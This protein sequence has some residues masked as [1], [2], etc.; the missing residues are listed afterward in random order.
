MNYYE[1]HLGDYAKD[2]G[3]LSMLEHGAYSLLLD[4][5]YT[6]EQ[7]IP[8]DQAHRVCRARSKE[9]KAAV[10][11][12][13]AEFF[14]LAAGFWTN[15]RADREIDKMRAKVKA[16]QENGKLG[17]RPKQ[18]QREP[19]GF[20]VGSHLETQPKAHQSPDTIHQS[21][22]K[23]ANAPSRAGAVCRLLREHGMPKTSP[24][25]PLLLKLLDAGCS[26]AE[27]LAFVPAA[28]GKGDPFAYML[29]AVKSERER[30]A[31][32]P[33]HQGRMPNK[34]EALEARNAAIGEE[35]ARKMLERGGDAAN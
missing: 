7:P 19:S 22:D 5:Y 31:V 17:G 15:G 28:L 20:V 10:D 23:G 2:A 25:H 4:R 8:E 21:P 26:D 33:L 18:T 3:H 9:E 30:A 34:Q 16:A 32:I 6:T 35:W 11:A 12:V 29:A 27:F 1:R 13:L 14:V 24:G